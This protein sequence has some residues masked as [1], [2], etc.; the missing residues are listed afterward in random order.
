LVRCP[1]AVDKDGELPF[2]EDVLAL[3]R[4]R[5][6]VI[7]T[8]APHRR[9]AP[10]GRQTSAAA[11][12]ASGAAEAT[13]VDDVAHRGG[14]S[15]RF[16]TPPVGADL[17][18]SPAER[19]AGSTYADQNLEIQP[20]QRQIRMRRTLSPAPPRGS[21]AAQTYGH[22]GSGSFL[23]LCFIESLVESDLSAPALAVTGRRRSSLAKGVSP[24]EEIPKKPEPSLPHFSRAPLWCRKWSLPESG[25]DL[26]VQRPHAE[27]R[28]LAQADG[29]RRCS[30]RLGY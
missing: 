28:A 25:A 1:R 16:V 21:R 24:A 23:R 17:P 5:K 26:V 3:L 4:S 22:R 9:V 8:G 14:E 2:V 12:T 27:Q 13:P 30:L 6:N 20:S 29:G 15:A 10:M 19:S 18:S 11:S 7:L